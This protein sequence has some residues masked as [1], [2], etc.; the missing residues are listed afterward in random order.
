MDEMGTSALKTNQLQSFVWF[1]YTDDIF[2]MW[3][4]GEEQLNLFL[5]DLNEFY[6]EAAT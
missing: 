5:K 2:F 4:L 1:I 3:T 6:P